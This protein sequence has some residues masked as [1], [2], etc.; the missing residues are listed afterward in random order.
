[1]CQYVCTPVYIMR[2]AASSSPKPHPQPPSK[3]YDVTYKLHTEGLHCRKQSPSEIVEKCSF[4]QL[5]TISLQLMIN[6]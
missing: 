4:Q 6:S 3:S 2:A 5:N 1:M